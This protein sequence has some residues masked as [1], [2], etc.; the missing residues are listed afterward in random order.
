M[1]CR[2]ADD[3]PR[4]TPQSANA[5]VAFSIPPTTVPENGKNALIT[6]ATPVTMLPSDLTSPV[7]AVGAW[8]DRSLK[9]DVQNFPPSALLADFSNST[10]A[11]ALPLI[12]GVNGLNNP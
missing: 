7:I 4:F 11:P 12:S 6:P 1:N 9:N 5:L 3:G 10:N 8:A 2:N